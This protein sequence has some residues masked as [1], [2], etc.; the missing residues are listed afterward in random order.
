MRWATSTSAEMARW[1]SRLR[2]ICRASCS[3]PGSGRFQWMAA[4]F[5]GTSA[6]RAPT[7]ARAGS[8]CCCRPA[9]K[10]RCRRIVSSTVHRPTTCSFSCGRS[11]KTRRTSHRP[12]R[13]SNS[14]R[15]IRSTAGKPPGRWSFPMPQVCRS[16]CCRSATAAPSM[17][18]RNWWRA[19]APLSPTPIRSACWHR[20]ASP[21]AG[22]SS[23]APRH[24]RSSIMPRRRPTR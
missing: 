7:A 18:S 23:P 19:R 20:S 10:E 8:F 14:P 9:T 1:C 3:M 13:S 6:C 4:G 11:I 17:S 15:S 24:G 21:R 12:S 16:T 2:P 5:L 22:P